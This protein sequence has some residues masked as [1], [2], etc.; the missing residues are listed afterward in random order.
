M[1]DKFSSDSN[2][3]MN[4]KNLEDKDESQDYSD[5]NK[6]NKESNPSIKS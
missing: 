1:N 4:S 5:N 3:I 2:Y 6:S